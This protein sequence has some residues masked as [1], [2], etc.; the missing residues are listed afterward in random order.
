M[1]PGGPLE[2]EKK[3]MTI[4]YTENGTETTD[5][6]RECVCCFAVAEGDI[7]YILKHSENPTLSPCV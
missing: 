4:S 1:V 6:Q 3:H 7:A 5:K 2:C